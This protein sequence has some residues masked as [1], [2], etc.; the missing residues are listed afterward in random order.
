[1]FGKSKKPSRAST[2][3]PSLEK[4]EDRILLTTITVPAHDGPNPYAWFIY[5]KTQNH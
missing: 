4:M 3:L 1:M 2:S 5:Q